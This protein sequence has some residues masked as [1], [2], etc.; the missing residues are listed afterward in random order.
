M[1]RSWV[2]ILH[3]LSRFCF[4]FLTLVLHSYAFVGFFPF[5]LLLKLCLYAFVSQFRYA[6]MSTVPIETEEG[7]VSLELE[8]Q[9]VVS[10]YRWVLGTEL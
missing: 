10:H 8:L 1:F 2:Q 3:Y 7:T 5:N 9:V 6:H 4:I